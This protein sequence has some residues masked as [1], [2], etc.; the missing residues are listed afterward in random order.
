MPQSPLEESLS[1][2]RNRSEKL[3]AYSM[4]PP[5]PP[6]GLAPAN[7]ATTPANAKQEAAKA[8]SYSEAFQRHR[9]T[10]PKST[11]HGNGQG[12]LGPDTALAKAQNGTRQSNSARRRRTERHGGRQAT[13]GKQRARE[14]PA[15]RASNGSPTK[16]TTPVSLANGHTSLTQFA[17]P[18]GDAGYSILLNSQMI[19]PP[20][21]S[22]GSKPQAKHAFTTMQQMK[23]LKDAVEDLTQQAESLRKEFDQNPAPAS[24]SVRAENNQEIVSSVGSKARAELVRLRQIV[25]GLV[26][27][28]T[29]QEAAHMREVSFI[30]QENQILKASITELQRLR[31]AT[32]QSPPSWARGKSKLGPNGDVVDLE[33][34]QA[35]VAH[36]HAENARLE[37]R[38]REKDTAKS[39]KQALEAETSMLRSQMEAMTDRC[40]ALEVQIRRMSQTRADPALLASEMQEKAML[41]TQ[42]QRER[43]ERTLLLEE[44]QDL[45]IEAL[46]ARDQCSAQKEL[47]DS[48]NSKATELEAELED[49]RHHQKQLHAQIETLHHRLQ[50]AGRQAE[51]DIAKVR[52]AAQ[53]LDDQVG[54]PRTCC[55][56]ASAF[57]CLICAESNYD[58]GDYRTAGSSTVTDCRTMLQWC[59]LQSPPCPAQIETA[60]MREHHTTL[61]QD[62]AH[63]EGQ[64]REKRLSQS[65]DDAPTVFNKAVRFTDHC[66]ARGPGAHHPKA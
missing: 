20:P 30:K 52:S 36:T 40:E 10:T 32:A 63:L 31:E 17:D 14:T 44:N 50:I 16:A 58:R 7:R 61:E 51:S 25:K 13:P 18:D 64:V 37:Q 3:Q 47:V 35:L 42:L 43:K 9:R 57:S 56:W 41:D 60:R 19:P 33:E 65:P 5:P 39:E 59:R 66:H 6:P 62:K 29:Q 48:L 8:G 54:G 27:K 2:L 53:Q 26:A 22:P 45:E 49:E 38:V 24:D 34:L 1:S 15:Q 4:P 12:F 28:A 23:D 21:G 11:V 46:S 55:M